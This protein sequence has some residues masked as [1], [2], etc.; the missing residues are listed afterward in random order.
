LG[1]S[2]DGGPSPIFVLSR[3]ELHLEQLAVLARQARRDTEHEA[4]PWARLQLP[5][6]Q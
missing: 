1:N 2:H 4:A 3:G 5:I 6:I